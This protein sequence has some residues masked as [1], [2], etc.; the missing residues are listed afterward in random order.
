MNY[1]RILFLLLLFPLL[2]ASCTE[3]QNEVY[4][5]YARWTERNDSAF[6]SVLRQAKS[7]VE[8]SKSAY[9]ASWEEHCDW[10]ILRNY[11]LPASASFTMADSVPV[12]IL[13]RGSGSVSPLYSD[14]VRVSFIGRL[15][16]TLGHPQGYVFGFTGSSIN[17][18]EVFSPALGSPVAQAVSNGVVGYTTVLQYMHVGDRW[19]FY[20]HPSL[21]Y[22]ETAT[23]GIPAHSML[24]FTVQ[25][26]GIYRKGSNT[27]D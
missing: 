7:A 20:V 21:G 11:C 17:E 27:S 3:E 12:Q 24:T 19:R 26:E 10:R 2:C 14:S 23:S 5:E 25:L 16:P 13:K 1:P 6:S 9:G 4:D 22:K 8:Q 15:I 18:D